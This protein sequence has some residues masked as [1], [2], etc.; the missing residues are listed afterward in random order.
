MPGDPKGPLPINGAALHVEAAG[1]GP[2]VL[3]L[4]AGIADSRMWD[5]QFAALVAAGYRAVRYDLRGFGASDF[6]PGPFSNPDD[7]VAVLDAAGIDRAAVVG[8]S[9]GGLIAVDLALAHPDRVG[10][11]FL[12]APSVNGQ[13]PSE[14]IRRFWD[15]EEAALERGDLEE[16]TQINLRLWVDGPHRRP[17]QV[18]PNVRALVHQMQL[19][20]FQQDEPE[21]DEEI[22]TEPPAIHRLPDIA[23]PTHILVGDLDLEE[24]HLLADRL[25][26]EVP[27]ATQ[28]RLADTAHMPNME[29]PAAFNRLLI[30]F[31]KQHHP[32]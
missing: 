23:C 12:V 8:A 9:F 18:D 1:S 20:A 19:H 16:A 26:D 4:H 28:S 11:L 10:A 14:R 25:V 13:P 27:G 7:A 21:E 30:D 5:G 17:D 2:G 22:P 24:K 6:P 15:E 31:L 32:G 29:R 3:L